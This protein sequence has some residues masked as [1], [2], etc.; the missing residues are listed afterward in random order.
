MLQIEKRKLKQDAL[1][2]MIKEEIYH[3]FSEKVKE[4]IEKSIELINKTMGSIFE[5]IPAVIKQNGRCTK[6]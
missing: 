2:T 1:D 3:Q 5:R 6:C 4:T